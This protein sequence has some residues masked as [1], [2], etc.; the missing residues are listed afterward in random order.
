MM[1]LLLM[2]QD[3]TPEDCDAFWAQGINMDDWDYLIMAPVDTLAVNND[4]QDGPYG[5]DNYFLERLL[6]GVCD[7]R[8]YKATYRGT[9]YALGI[10]YHA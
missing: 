6:R 9:E 10:A 3:M 2:P 5:Q 1:L 8:W 7:N 4:A